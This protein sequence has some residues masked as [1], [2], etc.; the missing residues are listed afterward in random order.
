MWWHIACDALKQGK[1]LRIT[2]D[3]VSRVVEPHVVGTSTA[4]NPVMR[5]WQVSSTKPGGN[6][7][8]RLFRLDKTW[9]FTILDERSE[10]PRRG[11]APNDAE[12]PIIRCKV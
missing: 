1:R 9:R 8:W 10:A 2:Y 12:I 6:G 7:V 3:G 5:A 11:Y 4:G